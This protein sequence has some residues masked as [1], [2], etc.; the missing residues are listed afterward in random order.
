MHV[1]EIHRAHGSIV[2]DIEKMV[3]TLQPEEKEKTLGTLLT[4]LPAK[5]AQR[6]KGYQKTLA[7]LK[8]RTCQVNTRNKTYLQESLAYW[9]DLVSM[10]TRPLAESL[11]YVQNG[12]QPPPAPEPYSLNKR[13]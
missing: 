7:G 12:T 13:V 11:V 9:K 4:L 10:L 2:R 3:S 5:E 6:I 8:K 1:D